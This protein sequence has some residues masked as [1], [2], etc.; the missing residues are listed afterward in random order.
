MTSI[1]LGTRGGTKILHVFPADAEYKLFGRLVRWRVGLRWYLVALALPVAVTLLAIFL[2]SLTGGTPPDYSSVGFPFG[3]PDTPLWM[4]I[5]LLL[6]IF[7]LGFD[8][9]GEELGWRGFA[10]PRLLER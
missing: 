9:L 4:K 1:P 5:I 6:L 2:N 10:L 8:G 7:L 3:P